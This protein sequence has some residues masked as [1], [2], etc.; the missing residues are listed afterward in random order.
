MG[1]LLIQFFAR[2]E[3]IDQNLSSSSAHFTQLSRHFFIF[4]HIIFRPL[5]CNI[6]GERHMVFV[7]EI[8][9]QNAF[10]IIK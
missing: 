7:N 2:F 6:E 10:N 5:Q 1:R 9:Q 8:F 3:V 4:L